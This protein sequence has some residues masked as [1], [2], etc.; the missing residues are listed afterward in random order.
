MDIPLQIVIKHACPGTDPLLSCPRRK[1]PCGFSLRT[2]PSAVKA[3]TGYT[4]CTRSSCGALNSLTVSPTNQRSTETSTPAWSFPSANWIQIR[5]VFHRPNLCRVLV[6]VTSVAATPTHHTI[7]AG[8]SDTSPLLM[9][10]HQPIRVSAQSLGQITL[11]LL[12]IERKL[13][14]VKVI[15]LTDR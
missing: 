4:C 11:D 14:I 1:C 7:T 9:P 10:S 6:L 15:L 13:Q 3:S 5:P 2:I 8:R 12:L